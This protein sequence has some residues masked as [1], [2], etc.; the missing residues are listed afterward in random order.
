MFQKSNPLFI[1]VLLLLTAFFVLLCYISYRLHLVKKYKEIYHVAFLPGASI[2]KFSGELSN[3]YSLA[4]PYWSYSNKDG[5]RDKRINNNK[6]I[7]GKNILYIG[8][9]RITHKNPISMMNYVQYLRNHNIFIEMNELEKGKADNIYK[10]KKL[11]HSFNSI[12][13]VVSYFSNNPYGFETFCAELF[14]RM[15]ICAQTTASTN[16]GGYDILLK[17][18]DGRIGIVECKCYNRTHSVGRPL[19]QKL[20]GAN[21]TICAS[22]LF[23]ITTS[24]YSSGAVEY[25]YQCNVRLINGLEL[26]DLVR[27]FMIS[28]NENI[29]VSPYE[30]ALSKEDLRPYIPSDIYDFL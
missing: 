12:D 19:I 30:W 8:N 14:T 7:Y 16:D 22:N 10:H 9:Y 18:H 6:I 1:I 28:Q 25:A 15:G 21:Q 3:L 29:T 27:K 2:R 13:S 23:F 17:Y 11:I 26:L 20:V 4:F 24:Y 5:T